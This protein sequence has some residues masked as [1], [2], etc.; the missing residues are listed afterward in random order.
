MTPTPEQRI[1]ALESIKY[2]DENSCTF[3]TK[4]LETIRAAL[5]AP[6]PEVVTVKGAHEAVLMYSS[7]RRGGFS[8]KDTIIG[9]AEAF[10]N[11]L[12]IGR[13]MK[14]EKLY[15]GDKFADALHDALWDVLIERADEMPIPTIL[16][17]LD[18]LKDKVKENTK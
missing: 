5:Q 6:Q 9:L 2:H 11:G 4:H 8:R 16:G 18:I 10:P 14:I 3:P 17:V 7:K 13:I 1:A 12:R 15:F